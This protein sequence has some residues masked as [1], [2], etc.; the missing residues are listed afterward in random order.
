MSAASTTGALLGAAATQPPLSV[1]AERG[2][3]S[4]EESEEGTDDEEGGWRVEDFSAATRGSL[5]E[6]VIKTGYLWKKG[7]RRKVCCHLVRRALQCLICSRLPSRPVLGV[8]L[9]LDWVRI[10]LDV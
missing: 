4:G 5:D 10:P 9:D 1:I 8:P 3:G 6:T 2:S 7:E